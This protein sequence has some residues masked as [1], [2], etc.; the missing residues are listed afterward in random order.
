MVA[1]P[2]I[3]SKKFVREAARFNISAHCTLHTAHSKALRA[4]TLIELLIVLLL[5]GI[6]YGIA[7][8]SV[9]PKSPAEAARK[10]LSLKTIDTIFKTLPQYKKQDLTL[11]CTESKTCRLTAKG[12]ILSTFS[13]RETG[14][15]YR[16]NPDETL[17]SIDYPHIKTGTDEFRPSFA[18]RCRK[19]GFFDPQIIRV[20]ERWLYIHPYK[21]PRFFD[22]PVALVDAMRQ[23]DYLPDRAGYAQ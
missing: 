13:L 12:K 5:M 7:F 15:A 10:E 4:F 11:Y 1:P 16:L 8:N 3:I 6:V 9:M 23:S 14:I 21:K 17:Q 20:G 19:D 22:D 2:H 18:I